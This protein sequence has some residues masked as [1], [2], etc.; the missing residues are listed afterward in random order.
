MRSSPD[1]PWQQQPSRDAG[2]AVVQGMGYRGGRGKLAVAGFDQRGEK[3]GNCC[4]HFS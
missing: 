2:R 3:G 4:R 1:W